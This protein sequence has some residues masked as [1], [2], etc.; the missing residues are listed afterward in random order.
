MNYPYG[1]WGC[2]GGSGDTIEMVGPQRQASLRLRVGLLG[3]DDARRRAR[4]RGHLVGVLYVRDEPSAVSGAR[5]RRSSTS[6]TAPI[7]RKTSSRR[8]PSSSTTSRTESCGREL[9]HADLRELRPRGLRLEDG[10]VVGRL[11]RQR[12]RPVASTGTRRRSSSSGTTTAAGTIRSRRAYV[13][14]DGLG[15]RLPM[16]II[17]P[18]AKQGHVSHVHYE[19]G[20]IL[21]VRRGSRSAWRG[22]RR[23]TRGPRRPR[24]IA[25]TSRSAPR[26]FETIQT[27]R[28]TRIT[29]MHQPPISAA[30]SQ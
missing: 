3:S 7:G 26:E 11:A 14:Y 9:G 15:F 18:Y 25:S 29:S 8:R 17:S 12:D 5:I 1:A 28:S 2:P 23:A 21:Q 10:S 20:S 27:L 13:D 16:L 30:R 24:K 6:T 4:R 19:H 22:L